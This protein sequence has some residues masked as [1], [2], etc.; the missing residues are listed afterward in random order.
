M[1]A[2]ATG[3]SHLQVT[4]PV[5]CVLRPGHGTRPMASGCSV[6]C[7]SS[8]ESLKSEQV[9]ADVDVYIGVLMN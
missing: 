8:A 5:P 1:D 9:L 7:G 4:S 3:V 2:V 6:R